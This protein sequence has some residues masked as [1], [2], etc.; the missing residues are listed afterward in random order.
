MLKADMRRCTY[1]SSTVLSTTFSTPAFYA[2]EDRAPKHKRETSRDSEPGVH[3][4][5]WAPGRHRCAFARWTLFKTSILRTF[6]MA[7]VSRGGAARCSYCCL[8]SETRA[9]SLQA[10]SGVA[11]LAAPREGV[12]CR[13]EEGC[14]GHARRTPAVGPSNLFGGRAVGFAAL[15]LGTRRLSVWRCWAVGLRVQG[16]SKRRFSSDDLNESMI[17]CA[18]AARTWSGVAAGAGM[19]RARC[20]ARTLSKCWRASAAARS[21]AAAPG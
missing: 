16:P 3:P 10:A 17:F 15:G 11:T 4:P 21:A 5:Q 8:S 20:I 12:D 1:D 18:A 14:S 2:A 6:N 7:A 13:A 9:P 19:W